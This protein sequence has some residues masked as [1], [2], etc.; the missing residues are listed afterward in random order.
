[1]PS[2]IW[3]SENLRTPRSERIVVDMIKHVDTLLQR[4]STMLAMRDILRGTREDFKA[5]SYSGCVWRGKRW[6]DEGNYSYA[7]MYFLLYARAREG[8]Y[9]RELFNRLGVR[10][11]S[12]D[13]QGGHDSEA[14]L[15]L[16]G[17][18]IEC[19]LSHTVETG[20]AIDADVRAD[21]LA[22]NMA[23]RS[24]ADLFEDLT[25]QLCSFYLPVVLRPSP[26]VVSYRM[27]EVVGYP[28]R[29]NP[30]V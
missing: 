23:I 4:N 2:I 28:F 30:Q 22:T 27:L 5:L 25:R 11:E 20:L 6:V 3:R 8:T 10:Y 12:L 29:P 1:M 7:I 19:I 18:V 14:S 21:R 24:L 17:D 15:S 16:Q 26:I 9:L 13:P